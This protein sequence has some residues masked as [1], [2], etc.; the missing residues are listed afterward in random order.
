MPLPRTLALA[1][2]ILVS[3]KMFQP[4]YSE[5]LNLTEKSHKIPLWVSSAPSHRNNILDQGFSTC[6]LSVNLGP[7]NSLLWEDVLYTVGCL[8]ASLT[9]S[10]SKRTLRPILA[11]PM[12][13]IV[14]I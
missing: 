4:E 12:R 1:T 5:S 11:V 2:L 8:A 7:D 3:Q 6:V 9:Y 14:G 13:P 10:S